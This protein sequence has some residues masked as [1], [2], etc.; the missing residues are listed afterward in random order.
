[1]SE[2]DPDQRDPDPVGDQLR[3]YADAAVAALSTSA[4]TAPI[5][6]AGGPRRSRRRVWN[7]AAVAAVLVLVA[8]TAGVLVT[9]RDGGDEVESVPAERTPDEQPRRC[10]PAPSDAPT[11][12]QMDPDLPYVGAGSEVRTDETSADGRLVLV[13]HTRTFDLGG[14]AVLTAVAAT[15]GPTFSSTPDLRE[16]H[17]VEPTPVQLAICDAALAAQVP[18]LAQGL[19]SIGAGQVV[20]TAMISPSHRL[21]LRA[22]MTSLTGPQLVAVAE[23]LMWSTPRAEPPFSEPTVEAEAPADATVRLEPADLPCA[24]GPRDGP[25]E[26]GGM[27]VTHLPDG[28]QARGPAQELVDDVADD[29]ISGSWSQD[30]DASDGR[31]IRVSTFQS[32]DPAGSA[33]QLHGDRAVEEL[34][35]ARCDA[36]QAGGVQGIAPLHAVVSTGDE[37]VV[38]SAQDRGHGGVVVAGA[39]GATL[40][41]VLRVASGLR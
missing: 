11:A 15:R 7:A 19:V 3:R 22:P 37:R 26:L 29:D 14:G 6:A 36:D 40:D 17:A 18:S 34:E 1:M 21:T 16:P 31:T 39:A 13:E 38:V 35:L 41:E 20:L 5:A 23:E 32:A 12:E 4:A 30:F 8:G 27:W 24:T 9:G 10:Q 25:G 2:H 28:Y 33:R